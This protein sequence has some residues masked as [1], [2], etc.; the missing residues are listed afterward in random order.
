MEKAVKTDELL[1]FSNE[2]AKVQET[3]EQIKGRM[4]YLDQN[5]AMA[6]VEIRLYQQGAAK[7]NADP[8]GDSTLTQTK[9]A[10]KSSLHV[11]KVIA[12]GLIIFAAAALPIMIV[13][14]IIAIPFIYM[15]RNR[16]RK[17]AL[18]INTNEE[19]PTDSV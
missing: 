15:I 16:A 13:M 18:K 7:L 19:P 8:I 17:G 10:L 14:A 11:L 4:R 2:L 1:S 5:V 9:N 12:Q 6:T 3:I